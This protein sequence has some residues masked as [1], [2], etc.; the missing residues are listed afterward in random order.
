MLTGSAGRL[1]RGLALMM[2]MISGISLPL[3]AAGSA[4]ADQVRNAQLWVLYALN[5]P[6]AWQFSQG[7]GV[8]VAVIDSGVNP[9]VSDLAGSVTTGPDLTGVGTLATNPAWGLHGTWMASLIAG[10]GHGQHGLAGIRGVAPEARILSIRVITDR[11]DPGYAKYQAE[12]PSRGQHE[13]ATAIRLAVDRGAGV[14]SMSLGYDAPSL[15]VRAA[16]QYALN[17]NVVVIASSGN[18][19]TAQTAQG[20]GHAPYSFPANYPGVLGVAAINRSGLPA[21]FSSENL[22]VEVAAPGVNVP[23]QGRD[24]R[25]WLVSGTSPACALVAG[26]AALIKSDDP[27]LTAAQ[28]RHAITSTT[29]HR[30]PHGYDDTVGFG[31]VDATAALLAAK[32]LARQEPAGNTAVAKAEAS[33]YFGDGAAGVP[34][35]PVPPRGAGLLLAWSGL[36]AGCLLVLVFSGRLLLAKRGGRAGAAAAGLSAVGPPAWIAPTSGFEGTAV[37]LRYPPQG[38]PGQPYPG[39]PYPGQ[40]QYPGQPYPGQQYPGQGYP[41]QAFP[42]QGLLG[43]GQHGQGQPGQGY[44]GQQYPGQ[45]QAGQAFPPQGLPGQGQP[46]QGY[47][48]QQYTGWSQA[49]QAFPPQGL[50]GQGEPGQGYPGPGQLGPGQL[51]PGQ[52]GPGQL[53]PGY[54][55]QLPPQQ[56]GTIQPS[57][58]PFPLGGAPGERYPGQGY[59][60]QLPATRPL[61]GQPLP[62]QGYPGQGYTGPPPPPATPTPP[63][64]A[65]PV[66]PGQG[67]G[68]QLQPPDSR[69]TQPPP[70]QPFPPGQGAPDQVRPRQPFEPRNPGP[71]R[72]P[73]QAQP[74][75][76]EPF[77]QPSGQVQPGPLGQPPEPAQ[78]AEP[79][80]P[81]QPVPPPG[82]RM[83]DQAGQAPAPGHGPAA[84]VPDLAEPPTQPQS[85]WD[86]WRLDDHAAPTTPR[87]SKDHDSKDRD[88]KDKD[89]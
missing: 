4:S 11:S 23:A 2:A 9:G 24:G 76:R 63:P 79:A 78:A 48:G 27:R 89:A 26:V 38:H 41:G 31:T 56:P 72:R 29:T 21:Y 54:P 53:G 81:A 10:H 8:L 65:Q 51:G 1:L 45:S 64:A 82:P 71:G 84:E 25:Y 70:G 57:G 3:A 55:G 40:Q 83:A 66:P 73:E 68:D 87:D 80:R 13:L 86:A 39:Q 15:A 60:G 36:A 34:V 85:K 59:R 74:P 22:S 46:G 30:P 18:S 47:P 52:L 50:P 7:R 28:I 35:V 32:R 33:G 69:Q 5:V 62:P 42:P 37:D 75:P 12:P 14:I 17:H 16:L 88:S 6:A 58:Q 61:S 20:Q 43:Q 77:R 67:P 49:G 19:G 44:P